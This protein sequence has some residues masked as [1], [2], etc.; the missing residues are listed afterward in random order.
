M[1][2]N[3]QSSRNDNQ[4][5]EYRPRVEWETDKEF[6]SPHY[7]DA[8]GGFCA[9]VAVLKIQPA[10]RYS[11]ELVW[12]LGDGKYTRHFNST[13]LL[14]M[15][16]VQAIIHDAQTYVQQQGSIAESMAKKKAEFEAKKA[17]EDK[18]KKL[19]KKS[20]HEANLARRREEDRAR[21]AAGKSGAHR[22]K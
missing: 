11:Y 22:A 3:N 12:K 17:E 7:D 4:R 10:P 19:A 21:T 20:R 8:K 6:V 9:R 2:G 16:S 13:H 15:D 5:R 14:D 18:A 1:Y